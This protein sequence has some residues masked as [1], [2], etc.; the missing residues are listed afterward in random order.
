MNDDYNAGIRWYKV[1]GVT[2]QVIDTG[3]ISD[4]NYDFIYPSICAN[5]NGDVVIGYTRSG[6]GAGDYLGAYFSVGTTGTDGVTTF[7]PSTA[8]KPGVANYH[9]AFEGGGTRWGDYSATS[10]DPADP[11][12]FWTIQEW[13]SATN[14]WSTQI[15]EIIIP[16][17]GEARWLAAA[18]GSFSTSANWVSGATVDAAAHVIFSRPVDPGAPG[19]VVSFDPASAVSNDRLSVRQG[20]VTFDLN[21][22]TW[23]LTNTTPATP[24]ITIA[25][26]ASSPTVTFLNG[27]INSTNTAIAIGTFAGGSIHISSATWNNSGDLA[28]GGTSSARGGAAS[29]ILGDSAPATLSVGG[30]L[31][32]WDGSNFT[33]NSGSLS[34]GTIDIAGLLTVSPAHRNVLRVSNLAV[35]GT[36]RLD[37]GDGAAIISYTDTSPIND[38]SAYLQSGYHGGGWDGPGIASTSARAVANDISNPNKTALGYADSGLLGLSTFLGQ[39]LN[40]N[41]ILI[42]YTFAGDANLDGVV[43]ALDFNLLAMDFGDQSG[44]WIR[45]DFNYDGVTDTRDFEMLSTNF[46]LALPSQLLAHFV[47]EPHVSLSLLLIPSLM[48]A[49]R[50]TPRRTRA[51]NRQPLSP[52]PSPSFT[53]ELPFR[54]I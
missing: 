11:G 27:T 35:S 54:P 5:A 52:V 15:G 33:Y 40:G 10:R 36:G 22:A 2:N 48:R 19:Y 23:S 39:P 26:F 7:G 49:R 24:S 43:N 30:T 17:P 29:F 45:G 46:N 31:K 8:L 28:L 34:V 32:I 20:A 1:N 44:G 3:L 18:S 6:P 12:I 53:S 41:S 38:V 14:V 42:R 51:Y 16:D 50:Q 21:G 13:A 25:E 37:L 4:P 47:P 9:L